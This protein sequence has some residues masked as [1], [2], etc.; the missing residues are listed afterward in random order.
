MDQKVDRRYLI[1]RDADSHNHRVGFACPQ[2]DPTGNQADRL[3]RKLHG[4]SLSLMAKD[5]EYLV[6]IRGVHI[7]DDE[8]RKLPCPYSYKY[9]DGVPKTLRNLSQFGM[10][11]WDKLAMVPVFTLPKQRPDGRIHHDGS[12]VENSQGKPAPPQKISDAGKFQ[13]GVVRRSTRKREGPN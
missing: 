6:S 9:I 4:H 11:A 13:T 1:F 2:S 3:T 12:S 5:G 7:I 10:Y 8:A